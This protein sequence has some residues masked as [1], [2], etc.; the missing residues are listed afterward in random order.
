VVVAFGAMD[1]V[2]HVLWPGRRDLAGL[3]VLD[4]GC[5]RR[6][7]HELP[8]D[9]HITGIDEDADALALNDRL[10]VAIEADLTT[11]RFPPESFDLIICQDVLEHVDHPAAVIGALWNAL[12]PGGEMRLGFPNVR[13]WKSRVARWTPHWFHVLVYKVVFRYPHAGEPGYGPYPT[14]LSSELRVDRVT[15]LLVD[16]G[17]DV[18]VDGY[19]GTAVTKLRH[20]F[21]FIPYSETD[22]IVTASKE[23]CFEL[24]DLR[25]V[26]ERVST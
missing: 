10:D 2:Q 7:K 24:P 12:A 14:V 25:A 23:K 19:E 8:P 21:P 4:A 13:N 17:A 16:R 26:P 9:A 15:Q 18:V 5:G 11:Y 20:R 3:R 6:L 22:Y 1:Y